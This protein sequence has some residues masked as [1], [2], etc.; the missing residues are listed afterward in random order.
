[1]NKPVNEGVSSAL[2]KIFPCPPL[3]KVE[4]TL[5]TRLTLEKT[6]YRNEFVWK[7]F[8]SKQPVSQAAQALF[9][10]HTRIQHN[11]ASNYKGLYGVFYKITTKVVKSVNIQ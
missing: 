1:M 6:L 9:M 5:G 4:K 11:M 10:N 3:W 7:R 2:A 8:A